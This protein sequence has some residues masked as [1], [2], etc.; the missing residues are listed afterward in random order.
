MKS[1]DISRCLMSS[2]VNHCLQ[3]EEL[4]CLAAKFARIFSILRY[5]GHEAKQTAYVLACTATGC[6]AS[7]LYEGNEIITRRLCS[8]HQD[9]NDVITPTTARHR[10]TRHNKSS[11]TY[12]GTLLS[13]GNSKSFNKITYSR[14]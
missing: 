12:T 4:L 5:V 11:D 8:L 7:I 3:G 9:G 2:D 14:L 13:K 10:F 6:V 1:T